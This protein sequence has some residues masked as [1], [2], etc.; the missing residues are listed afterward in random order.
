VASCSALE[1]IP[2]RLRPLSLLLPASYPMEAS[3]GLA[4][5][6]AATVAPWLA[7]GIL[8]AGGVA[9]F[10]LTRLCYAWEDHGA[11]RRLRPALG[12]LAITPY[13]VAAVVV[14]V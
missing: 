5:G 6:A 3:R 14:S 7:L 1:Q 9:A 2:E 8:A 4:L 13:L 12:V 10:V 11:G